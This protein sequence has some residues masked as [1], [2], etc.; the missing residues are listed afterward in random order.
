MME[1]ACAVVLHPDGAPLR[2]LAFEHPMAGTQFV[3]GTIEPGE[4][5]ERAALRELYEEAGLEATAALLLGTSDDIAVGERW[6]FVLCRAKSPVR[7]E[8]QHFC[9]DDGGHLF[10]FFWGT[11]ESLERLAPPFQNALRE[12]CNAIG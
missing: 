3:K 8:W 5:P 11:P 1:K 12:I 9:K 4:S 6:H 2:L 7:A 10:R